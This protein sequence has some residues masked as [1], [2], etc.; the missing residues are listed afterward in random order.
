[1]IVW[2]AAFLVILLAAELLRRPS[3]ESCCRVRP[4]V[5]VVV[6]NG[7]YTV[8]TLLCSAVGASVVAAVIAS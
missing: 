7:A 6:L 4:G 5:D 2:V 8:L 1:M 3:I